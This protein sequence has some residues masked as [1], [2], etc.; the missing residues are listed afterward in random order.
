MT[1]KITFF[2]AMTGYAMTMK[3]RFWKNQKIMGRKKSSIIPKGL[4]TIFE[5]SK[6]MDSAKSTVEGQIRNG[7]V[8]AIREI[9][10]NKFLDYI[11]ARKQ[12]LGRASWG[13]P[14]L[15]EA[16]RKKLLEPPVDL[17]KWRKEAKEKGE[18][19]AQDYAPESLGDAPEVDLGMTSDAG[20]SSEIDDEIKPGYKNPLLSKAR[21]EEF[22]ARK[23]ELL[24][25]ELEGKLIAKEF[26]EKN[27]ADLASI[28]KTFLFNIPSRLSAQLAVETDRDKIEKLIENEL[29][30]SLTELCNRM[31]LKLSGK[32]K[33][34][35]DETES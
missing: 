28:L 15:Q 4:V 33:D 19:W 6:L 14:A 13:K 23:S 2:R 24:V 18:Y 17:Y 30:I 22:D 7:T 20:N 5:F 16:A 11:E 21:K 29:Q 25:A 31:E 9:G 27:A 3:R 35:D 12:Y 10:G 8:H 34:N 32:E 26:V 1:D